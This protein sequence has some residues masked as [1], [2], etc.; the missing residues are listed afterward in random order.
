M[1]SAYSLVFGAFLLGGRLADILGRQGVFMAGLVVF[2]VGSL[3]CGLAWSDTALIASRAL[4][5]LGA[6]TITPSALSILTTTFHEGATAASRSARRCS[7][8]LRRR[9]GR[10]DGRD[11]T[12]LL[13]WE[14][15]F[16]V[17]VPVGVAAL[18][19]ATSP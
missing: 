14:W 2:S 15:I 12:D 17:N 3:L 6:A 16:F 7:R 5:G 8:G 18:A 1:I 10:P 9:R 13:S 19:L 11:L 4:Q